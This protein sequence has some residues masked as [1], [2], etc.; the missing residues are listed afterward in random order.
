MKD[1]QVA[2]EHSLRTEITE[3]F[4]NGLRSL[5]EEHNMDIP[6]EQINV[7]DE[8]QGELTTLQQHLDSVME[9]NM[10]LK[11]DLN[12]ATKKEVL[13]QVVEG[14]AATQAEKLISLAEGVQ[15]DS[16]ENYRKKLEIVKENY[17]P[18]DKSV[19][20]AP[21]RLEELNEEQ[22]QPAAPVNSPV[23]KYVSAISRTVKK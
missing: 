8:L 7:V 17:F 22:S 20:K 9:E 6:E 3:G 19:T 5:F 14:L 21:S 11:N 10:A 12:E 2:I 4:I 1:N 13:S 23:L 16:P 18:S 15:F